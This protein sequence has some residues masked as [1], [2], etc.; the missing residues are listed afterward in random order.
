M[1]YDD[2]AIQMDNSRIQIT[3]AKE[4]KGEGWCQLDDFIT[5]HWKG[6]LK[7]KKVED[8]KAF[9]NKPKVF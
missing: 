2:H 7:G 3:K 8:S 6:Y 4:N 5:V 1:G 9:L